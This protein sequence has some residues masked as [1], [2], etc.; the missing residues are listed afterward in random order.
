MRTKRHSR[1]ALGLRREKKIRKREHSSKYTHLYWLTVS[2]YISSTNV[3]SSRPSLYLYSFVFFQ[4][5]LCS[6]SELETSRGSIRIQHLT[7]AAS[8]Q[9][10]ASVANF[11]SLA[12]SNTILPSSC[13]NGNGG[14]GQGGLLG[15][16]S[17]N[18]SSRFPRLQS[19]AHFHYEFTDIGPI[20][21][22]ISLF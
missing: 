19:C 10:S 2:R 17:E 7:A 5:G 21:V 11:S 15:H 18:Q 6:S 16:L 22:S 9:A 1:K 14:P 8:T 20:S 12:G 3:F 13:L 4:S